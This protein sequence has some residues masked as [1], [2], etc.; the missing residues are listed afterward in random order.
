[1]PD[2]KPDEIK[3]GFYAA[4][5]SDIDAVNDEEEDDDEGFGLNQLFT[6]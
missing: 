4:A 5:L 3:F 1:M 2:A 6:Q